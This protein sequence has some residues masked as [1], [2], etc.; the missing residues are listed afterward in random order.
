MSQG[1]LAVSWKPG[2]SEGHMRGRV[3]NMGV[4]FLKLIVAL[5][6]IKPTSP[7]YTNT[8]KHVCIAIPLYL[9]FVAY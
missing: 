5:D 9:Y 4:P 2:S 1:R 6:K 7:A 8:Y 3:L